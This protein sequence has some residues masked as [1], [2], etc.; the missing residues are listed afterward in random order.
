MLPQVA[1][2]VG[3]TRLLSTL[4]LS[5]LDLQKASSSRI[6]INRCLLV[7]SRSLCTFPPNRDRDL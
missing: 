6:G 5:Y 7:P 4:G 1:S 3:R 2:S